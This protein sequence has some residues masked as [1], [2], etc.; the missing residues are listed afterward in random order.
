MLNGWNLIFI[1]YRILLK[2]EDVIPF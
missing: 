2:L 1:G